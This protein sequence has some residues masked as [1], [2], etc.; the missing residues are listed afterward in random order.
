MNQVIKLEEMCEICRKRK[1]T[2]LCDRIK[3]E[4]HWAGHPPAYWEKDEYTG[5][6][7]KLYTKGPMSG[8]N[9]CDKKLCDM[10]ATHVIGMDLCPGCF[11]ELKNT[12]GI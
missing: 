7:Y 6:M 5:E 12:L 10:C 1:A 9:T 8:I 2:K 11:N 3:A 4:W